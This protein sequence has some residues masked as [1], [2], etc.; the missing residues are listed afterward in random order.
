[1]ALTVFLSNHAS[2]VFDLVASGLGPRSNL[3]P[4]DV[5]EMLK[6]GTQAQISHRLG[7]CV[8][9]RC[10]GGTTSHK[11]QAEELDAGGVHFGDATGIANDCTSVNLV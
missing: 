6:T 10:Y 3:V 4:I 1:M 8:A 7:F 11:G 9:P 2:V 5:V